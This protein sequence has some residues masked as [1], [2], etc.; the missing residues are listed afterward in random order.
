MSHPV[1]GMSMHMLNL[2]SW[3]PQPFSSSERCLA[4]RLGLFTSV[5]TPGMSEC[6]FNTPA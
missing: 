2:F 3:F 5:S 6:P 4:F 1:L